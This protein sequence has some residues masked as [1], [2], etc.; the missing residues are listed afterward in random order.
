MCA[1]LEAGRL[2]A[3]APEL[4]GDATFA[5]ALLALPVEAQVGLGPYRWRSLGV[6]PRLAAQLSAVLLRDRFTYDAATQRETTLHQPA[7]VAFQTAL[8]VAV[9]LF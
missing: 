2:T 7:P 3:A 5:R 9:H 1:G 6:E 8:G 4:A